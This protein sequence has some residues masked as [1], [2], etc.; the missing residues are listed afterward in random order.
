MARWIAKPPL[1]ARR[2][3][4][5]AFGVGLVTAIA[6]G[7]AMKLGFVSVLL[8]AM[9]VAVPGPPVAVKAGFALISVMIFTSIWGL[10]VAE[11]ILHAPDAGIIVIMAGIAIAGVVATKPGKGLIATLMV[12][13][14][15]VIAVIAY[16][17][18]ATAVAVAKSL[19]AGVAIGVLISQIAHV[20]FPED[21]RPAKPPVAAAAAAPEDAG[22]SSWIGLRSAL[23]MLPP[24]L[25]A[26]N[27]PSAYIVLLMKGS[28]LTQQVGTGSARAVA[29][30]LVLSTA[31]G[32]ALSVLIWWVLSLWPG[33]FLF[34]MLLALVTLWI[35]RPMYGAV[36]SKYRFEHWLNV[37]VTLVILIGPA[38]ADADP[39]ANIQREMLSRLLSFILLSLY[40]AGM[41]HLLDSFRERRRAAASD[42]EPGR[43]P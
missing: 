16:Q 22:Q 41:V 17:S 20:F 34:V 28:A 35:A 11:V 23:I 39:S 12:L 19:V 15:T 4:R 2:C 13:G 36:K 40:A 42:A 30:E 38:V 5:L 31:L 24:V 33:L 43:H 8:A 7:A 14:N 37:L 1:S 18:S 6:Y 25:L 3:Y 27:N 10:L 29:L 32:G 21:P 26:L 9:F